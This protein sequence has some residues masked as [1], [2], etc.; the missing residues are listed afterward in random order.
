MCVSRVEEVT[1]RSFCGKVLRGV[2]NFPLDDL[3]TFLWG[4]PYPRLDQWQE[5]IEM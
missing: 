5:L 1:A 2:D 3:V 4:T